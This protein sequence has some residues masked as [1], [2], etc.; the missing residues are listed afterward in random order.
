MEASRKSAGTH[1]G[2]Q[3]DNPLDGQPDTGV[4]AFAGAPS[5]GVTDHWDK[6]KVPGRLL[7]VPSSLPAIPIGEAERGFTGSKT[8]DVSGIPPDAAQTGEEQKETRTLPLLADS[9]STPGPADKPILFSYSPYADADT[10]RTHPTHF[11]KEE[12]R[13]MVMPGKLA[14]A[15]TLGLTEEEM[16]EYLSHIGE[17]TETDRALL[18]EL[19]LS[20]IADPVHSDEGNEEYMRSTVAIDHTIDKG[21]THA[22]AYPYGSRTV[23]FPHEGIVA[24]NGQVCIGHDVRGVGVGKTA[25]FGHSPAQ[26]RPQSDAGISNPERHDTISYLQ[27]RRSGVLTP[28][29]L[30]PVKLNAFMHKGLPVSARSYSQR[31]IIQDHRSFSGGS[32]RML[33]LYPAQNLNMSEEEL[34]HTIDH[35]PVVHDIAMGRAVEFLDDARVIDEFNAKHKTDKYFIG[36]SPH[37]YPG[38]RYE[39]R[40]SFPS[41]AHAFETQLIQNA[42]G[43]IQG[44]VFQQNFSG[45]N[46]SFPSGEV[47]D[48]DASIYRDGKGV[49]WIDGKRFVPAKDTFSSDIAALGYATEYVVR[50]TFDAVN[51]THAL[52]GGKN[53]QLLSIDEVHAKVVGSLPPDHWLADSQ[54][55]TVVD[56]ALPPNWA[57]MTR[58]ARVNGA[59]KDCEKWLDRYA[60]LA[61]AVDQVRREKKTV[62]LYSE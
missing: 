11:Y 23:V 24:A 8:P 57:H 29:Q 46:V 55:E 42:A 33:G 13:L 60:Q 53:E 20:P 6:G 5:S 32:L 62:N 36:C 44:E 21:D 56:L 12:K 26:Q 9:R 50:Q 31:P 3:E 22:W 1:A 61:K 34:Q 27:A 7:A 48:W 49:L 51:F 18:T 2:E 39:N 25:F 35:L 17:Q 19:G 37:L 14:D 16:E 40:Y 59:L 45:H 47:G 30:W 52:F 43:M 58:R 10:G 54:Y 4:S 28:L 38:N 15:R 41:L